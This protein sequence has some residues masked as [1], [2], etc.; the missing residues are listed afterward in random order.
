MDALAEVVCDD[1]VT[2][3]TAGVH[4]TAQWST[5]CSLSQLQAHS[6]AAALHW[7]RL[8]GETTVDVK[9]FRIK[10]IVL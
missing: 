10:T 6:P 5:P 1:R 9:G 7:R 2:Y 3:I 8:K 4:I